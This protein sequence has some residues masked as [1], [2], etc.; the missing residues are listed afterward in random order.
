[1]ARNSASANHVTGDGSAGRLR[2]VHQTS[3]AEKIA[4]EIIRAAAEGRFGLG[5]R[6]GLRGGGVF[7]GGLGVHGLSLCSCCLPEVSSADAA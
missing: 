3:L 1:M 2:V 7:G 5:E 4:S 6:R